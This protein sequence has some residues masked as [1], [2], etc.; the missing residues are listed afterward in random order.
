MDSRLIKANIALFKGERAET[1]RFLQ[2]YVAEFG[3]SLER[4]PDAPLVM[5]LDA[6]AQTERDERLRRLR[7][8][9]NSVPAQNHYCQMARNT[10]FEEARL[11]GRENS[12]ETLIFSSRSFRRVVLLALLGVALAVGAAAL[13]TS[14][15]PTQAT[16]S[17][18]TPLPPSPTA[19]NLPDLSQALVADSFSAHYPRGVLQVVALEEDSKR[20]MDTREQT[21]ATPVPGA[22]FYALSLIFECRGGICDQPPEAQLALQLDNGDLIPLRDNA[23]I[24]GQPTLQPIALGRTSA[25]WVVFEVPLISTVQAL[26][27]SPPDLGSVETFEPVTI[28]LPSF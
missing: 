16:K 1:Q 4:D 8:L 12:H 21:L 13:L 3:F 11:G 22:R 6:Q 9:V 5:W 24:A 18:S 17:G 10:L 15:T 14:L 2:E 7:I 28:P 19:L 25:G 26:V 23:S 20:V 27:V